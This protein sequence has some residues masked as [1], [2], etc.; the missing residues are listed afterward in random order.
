MKNVSDSSAGTGNPWRNQYLPSSGMD[1]WAA[2]LKPATLKHPRAAFLENFL[3]A[4]SKNGP[5]EKDS[6]AQ[7]AFGVLLESEEYDAFVEVFTQYQKIQAHAHAGDPGGYKRVLELRLPKDWVPQDLNVM[8]AAFEKIQVDVLRISPRFCGHRP[9]A[10]EATSHAVAALLGGGLTELE[11]D[12]ILSHPLVVEEALKNCALKSIVL[13]DLDLSDTPLNAQDQ[14]AFRSLLEG[15]VGCK[16]L[17]KLELLH[18]DLMALHASVAA[19]LQHTNGPRLEDVKLHSRGR[20]SS[21]KAEDLTPFMKVLRQVP[22]LL[23]LEISTVV[24]TPLALK[25]TLL[26]PMKAHPSLKHLTVQIVD[27]LEVDKESDRFVPE[28]LA[29][30]ATCP[31][32][33]HVGLSIPV[34]FRDAAQIMFSYVNQGGE[35][36]KVNTIVDVALAFTQLAHLQSIMFSGVLLTPGLAQALAKGIERHPSFKSLDVAGCRSDLKSALRFL[37]VFK[38]HE[39]MLNLQLLDSQERVCLL[40]SDGSICSFN[41][42]LLR[43]P[44]GIPLPFEL[45]LRYATAMQKSAALT[46]FKELREATHRMLDDLE[47]TNRKRREPRVASFMQTALWSA[48]GGY[49]QYFV[50][51]AP[52]VL[53]WLME[54]EGLKTVVRL[55]EV[56]KPAAT[57]P[58]TTAAATTTTT[59]TAATTT[60]TTTTTAATTTG[61]TTSTA[62][63]A[64]QNRSPDAPPPPLG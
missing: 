15:L 31:Q 55:N 58:T 30:A 9:S 27:D 62:D 36:D 33:K 11:I 21:L 32:L 59:T 35:L 51:E 22:T 7:A 34:D 19:F 2:K 10:P 23:S 44:Q 42:R 20:G 60:T 50:Q 12:A 3:A 41:G 14:A 49:E 25:E 18:H 61:S 37:E 28:M 16:S 8:R 54:A 29:C 1:A 46:T 56:S 43:S 48:P 52:L 63:S 64:R 38:A 26:D 40:S 57:T 13:G 24:S 53:Q 4:L 39:T 5:M 6:V 45:D 47:S 17:K